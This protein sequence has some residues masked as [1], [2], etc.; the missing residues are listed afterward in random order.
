MKNR[1]IFILVVF[2]FIVITGCMENKEKNEQK[3]I[4]ITDLDT[5]VN[6]GDD[7][8]A[9][10]NGGWMEKYPIPEEYGRF[11]T[12]DKLA[13]DN[14]EMVKSLVIS[15]AGE[16]HEPGSIAEKI[17][18]FYAMG[19]DTVK[20][21][22]EGI[23]P[24]NAELEKIEGL[25]S[26][27]DMQAHVAYLHTH[28]ISPFFGF[29]GGPDRKNSN[30]NIA[31]VFQGGLGL[32]DR[33]Y[34]VKD[35]PRSTEIREEYLKHVAKMFELMGYPTDKAI[36]AANTI[37]DIETRMA[38]ASMTRLERRDPHKTY[39]KMSFDSLQEIAPG[40][41]WDLYFTGIGLDEPGGL[42]VGQ[43][44]FF[45]EISAMMTEIPLEDLK[46]YLK[47]NLLNHTAPYLSSDFEKQNFEFYGKVLRGTEKQHP[48][49]K[50]V[51]NTTESA[52]GEALGQ[53]Y[54]EKYFPPEAKARMLDLVENLRVSLGNRIDNL[55]WMS[56]TTKLKARE[57]LATMQVKIG[58][59]DKWRDYSK[60]DIKKDTYL[61]N[62]LR[63]KKFSFN[64]MLNKIGK[65]V[66]PDE[67]HM[68]PQTVNAYYNPLQNEICFPA[69][70]LQPPFFF[71]N[72][73]DA[74]NYGAIGVVIGHEMTHGFDDQGRKFDKEGNLSEWWT[75]SDAKRFD[76]RTKVLVDQYNAFIVLDSTHADGELTLGEN[77]ADLGGLNISY[78]A[79]KM[80]DPGDKEING[81][82][83]DQRFF[84]AY[85]HVW[86]QNIRDKEISR[87][88][89][90]D[91]HSLGK[92]RVNGPLPHLEAF[93]FAFGINEGDP[94]YLP[95]EKRAVIW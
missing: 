82:T 67:W 93:H 66:D 94:M 27:E 34:Y 50:R 47:W 12:F 18:V 45:K 10:A 80:T 40:I 4:D 83:P 14:E 42:N 48:R 61:Q 15:L 38:K 33:D 25:K 58:Y 22:R 11:G 24:I 59:P 52:M 35:D 79:F 77:I 46:I 91:V 37:M 85:A 53:M 21:D 30:M 44:G 89:K 36:I 78:D 86:G 87:R 92:F 26:K 7:F 1:N 88:T 6:P 72:A 71:M 75:E 68:T 95:L 8:Y 65:P 81:F 49:W 32:T 70:I 2:A 28:R 43:P 3:A 31:Q 63:G 29:Y 69:G 41:S 39:N 84:L 5:T 62:V 74:V 16:E 64:Y 13:R 73:D 76:E 17:G 57:K 19:M 56:D 60:L 54:V 51:L 55:D 23:S 20:L 90:E 9:Y